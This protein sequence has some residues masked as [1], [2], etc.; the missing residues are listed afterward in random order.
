MKRSRKWHSA[1]RNQRRARLKGNA[2]FRALGIPHW[3][4]NYFNPRVLAQ[5]MR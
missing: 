2:L 1:Q 4:H 3:L 5:M